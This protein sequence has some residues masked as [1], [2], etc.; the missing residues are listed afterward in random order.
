MSL[1]TTNFFLYIYVAGLHEHVPSEVRINSPTPNFVSGFDA[2]V[3]SWFEV[4]TN[5]Y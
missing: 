1:P 2:C 5:N 3:V 4:A